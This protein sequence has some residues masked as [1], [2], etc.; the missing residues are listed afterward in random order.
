MAIT[1]G[2]NTYISVADADDY[3]QYRLHSD[4]WTGA[5]NDEK[6]AALAQATRLLD[7]LYDFEGSPADDDQALAWPR[8]NAYDCENKPLPSDTVPRCVLY[9]TCEEALHLL[10]GDQISAP[11][12]P[13]QGFTKAKLDVLEIEV[14]DPSEGY[15]PDKMSEMADDF[16]ACVGTARP[17]AFVNR[18]GVAQ[19]T[20]N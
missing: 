7:A 8:I 19:I 20:R 6:E 4:A 18:G 11:A 16:L 1:V 3:F 10:K 5:A 9:A 12:L 17:G 14:A 15:A 13:G 2:E